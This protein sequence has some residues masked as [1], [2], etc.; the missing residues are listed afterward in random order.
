MLAGACLISY[1]YA[2]QG[3]DPRSFALVGA[4]T[5]GV[6][7]VAY[8][9]GYIRLS[10]VGAACGSIAALTFFQVAVCD[11]SHIVLPMAGAIAG[12]ALFGVAGRLLSSRTRRHDSANATSRD[13]VNLP[14]V[15]ADPE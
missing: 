4:I 15:V 1:A 8:A 2:V 6:I 13:G 12:L 7:A 10:L 11:G 5:G 3:G 14:F 9:E